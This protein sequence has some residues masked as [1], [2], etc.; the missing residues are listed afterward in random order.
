MGAWTLRVNAW[1]A[2][3][4]AYSL[5]VPPCHPRTLLIHTPAARDLMSCHASLP[6]LLPWLLPCCVPN[7]C[8]CVSQVAASHAATRPPLMSHCRQTGCSTSAWIRWGS[9]HTQRQYRHSTFEAAA[10]IAHSCSSHHWAFEA[11]AALPM[12]YCL[13]YAPLLAWARREADRSVT[14]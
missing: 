13:H 12:L 7:V 6:P 10:A 2:V 4:L 3:W 1:A 9:T 14:L 8:V 11:T 5:P